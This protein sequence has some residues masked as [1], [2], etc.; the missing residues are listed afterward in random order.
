MFVNTFYYIIIIIIN[1]KQIN[2]LLQFYIECKEYSKLGVHKDSFISLEVNPSIQ[3][4]EIPVCEYVYSTG[5]I[6]GG[7]STKAGEFPHMVTFTL[8]FYI[9]TI[10]YAI[11]IIQYVQLNFR[12]LLDGLMEII[13]III[14]VAHLL[15]M[16]L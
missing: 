5:L 15:V 1:H 13:L 10:I 8:T 7:E 12:Q 6:V 14:V 2:F 3:N 4:I 9:L 11:K 16:N